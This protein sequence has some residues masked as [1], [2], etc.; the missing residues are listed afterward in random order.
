MEQTLAP[1]WDEELSFVG[2]LGELQSTGLLVQVCD[3]D[4]GK[5]DD[6]LGEARIKLS[7]TV[8]RQKCWTR[9]RIE[10]ALTGSA[11]SE[12]FPQATETHARHART[13]ALHNT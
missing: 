9:C 8:M 4:Q 5:A 10:V 13:H 6:F 7:D 12:N 1:R 2:R 3:R 11:T